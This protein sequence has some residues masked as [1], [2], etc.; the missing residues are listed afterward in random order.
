MMMTRRTTDREADI[1]TARVLLNEA[2]ARRRSPSFHATL[3]EWA[4]NARRRAAA[5]PRELKQADLFMETMR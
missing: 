5:V 2:R 1:H 4:A 3:L